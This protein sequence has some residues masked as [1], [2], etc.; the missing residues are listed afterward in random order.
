ME[1][2]NL[3]K[4]IND[5]LDRGKDA[6]VIYFSKNNTILVEGSREECYKTIQ[7]LLKGDYAVTTEKGE[8]RENNFFRFAFAHRKNIKKELRKFINCAKKYTTRDYYIVLLIKRDDFNPKEVTLTLYSDR[9]LLHK[10]HK[11]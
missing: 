1:Y 5:A 3:I 7:L 8:V 6:I 11:V 10:L 2:N 9:R 4:Q